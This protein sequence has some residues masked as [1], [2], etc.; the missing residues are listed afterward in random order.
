MHRAR[1]QIRRSFKR[2]PSDGRARLVG[3][4]CQSACSL[5]LALPDLLDEG[6]D[7]SHPSMAHYRNAAL[8]YAFLLDWLSKQAA[9]A[10]AED[11]EEG[12]REP[13]PGAQ[14]AGAGA[15]ARGSRSF[16]MGAP[17]CTPSGWAQVHD[18]PTN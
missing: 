16:E 13:P 11:A 10:A 12:A 6:L 14:A 5:G 17:G 8:E 2:I 1:C 7:R 9:A 18:V 3:A 15:G 4:L